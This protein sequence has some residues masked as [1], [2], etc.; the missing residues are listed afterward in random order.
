M[1]ARVSRAWCSHCGSCTEVYCHSE[2]K[3]GSVSVKLF[4]LVCKD[5][6]FWCTETDDDK[7][8]VAIL[9]HPLQQFVPSMF[10]LDLGPRC[11]F[12]EYM[13][14]IGRSATFDDAKRFFVG[15]AYKYERSSA[16]WRVEDALEQIRSGNSI[17]TS[18]PNPRK[19]PSHGPAVWQDQIEVLVYI[20]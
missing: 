9:R 14:A 16:S 1:T 11:R 3:N 20:E 10:T 6:L 5:F 13:P 8:T 19:H 15:S 4:H 18:V 17:D 12:G 2:T 7:S